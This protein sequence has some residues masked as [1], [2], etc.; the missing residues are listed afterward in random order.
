[1]DDVK[2]VVNNV[3][4]KGNELTLFTAEK[5]VFYPDGTSYKLDTIDAI[6]ELVKFRGKPETT[7]IFCNEKRIGIILDDSVMDRQQDVA[8]FA[9]EFS[10]EYKEWQSV[11]GQ[12]LSQKKFVDFLKLRE[13]EE[14]DDLDLLL[15]QTQN[16]AFAT[17]IVG[18]FGYEDSNNI[19]V[20]FK[21]KDVEGT[22]KIPQKFFIKIPLVFGS[23]LKV[24]MEIQLDLQKPREENQR[25]LFNITCPKFHRYWNEA[26]N[27][28]TDRLKTLLS[29]YKIV[30]GAM[31]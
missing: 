15:G 7:L 4:G 20:V 26:V 23:D 13:P 22:A 10:D 3:A 21:A 11:L 5:K 8:R 12:Q 27:H 17:S 9:F 28:E 2:V 16:L 1:M 25:P 14:V 18:E 6:A 29:D 24:F 19:T 30:S 31:E